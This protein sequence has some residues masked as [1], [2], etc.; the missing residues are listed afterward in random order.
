VTATVVAAIAVG[1]FILA[2][3]PA[4]ASRLLAPES[5]RGRGQSPPSRTRLLG[6]TAAGAAVWFAASSSGPLAP[7][8]GAAAAA[9]SYALLGRLQSATQLRRQARLVAELPQVC[10]L[11]VACLEAGLPLRAGA[12]A[13]AAGL[14]G[15]MA[16][17][18]AEV[19]AK[20]RLGIDEE[21]AWQELAVEPA[22]SGL[23]RELAR[24]A[25]SGVALAGRLR[26]L[27]LDARREAFAEAE[28]RAKKVGVQSV[29]PLMLCF[30][31]AFVLLG[32]LPIVGGLVMRFITP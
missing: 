22:L 4:R 5:P 17:R 27:G 2:I 32:V 15:P 23:G 8:L 16:E 7:I 18:L 11:L 14:E 13:V 26:A 6:S 21:R 10:D 9:L 24:G 1:L 25:G 19:V 20:V 29:L 31:P 30:L 3:S 28:A 12:E